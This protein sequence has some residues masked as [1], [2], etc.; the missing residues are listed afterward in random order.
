MPPHPSFFLKLVNYRSFGGFR[1]EFST[2]ADYELM[3]RMLYKQ[4]VKCVYLPR[5]LVKMRHGGKSNATIEN[6][7]R[8]NREDAQA[9][10]VNNLTPYIFTLWLKPLRKLGQFFM[11]G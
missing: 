4:H 1:T 11:K 5:V 3:L 8:A 2:A 10:K 6:R 7:L 9:W